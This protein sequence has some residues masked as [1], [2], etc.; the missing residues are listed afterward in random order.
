MAGTATAETKLEQLLRVS[1]NI[2]ENIAFSPQR[3]D[4]S[5]R[6]D[7]NPT[8]SDVCTWLN[9]LADFSD[10]IE[11]QNPLDVGGHPLNG[12]TA[13]ELLGVLRK[14]NK[15]YAVVRLASLPFQM[16]QDP[17]VIQTTTWTRPGAAG[18]RRSLRNVEAT[19][20]C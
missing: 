16:M 19:K 10:A 17:N 12:K 7:R 1:V 3:S 5:Y 9:R 6:D 20:A 8:N 14:L 13:A 11:P 2:A 18:K 15:K 4:F